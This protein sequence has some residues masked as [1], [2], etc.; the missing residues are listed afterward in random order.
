MISDIFEFVAMT[1]IVFF[2]LVYRLLVTTLVLLF[3]LSPL[4]LIGWIV[5]LIA[6]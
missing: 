3:I 1:V 5:W 6:T 2:A 4:I